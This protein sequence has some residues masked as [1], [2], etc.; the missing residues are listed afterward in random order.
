MAPPT[1]P[2]GPA[3][4][5]RALE[6]GTDGLDTWELQIKIIGWGSGSDNDGIGSVMD[7]VRV[8]GKFDTTT[9]D[10][11]KRFQ[12][13]H[14]L[15]VTGV[16]DGNVFRAI[17]DELQ[18]HPISIS[19][20]QCPCTTGKN[21]GVIPCRCPNHPNAGECK[22]FG[23]GRF[24]GQFLLDGTPLSGEKLAVY[25]MEE[26]AGMDKAV[27]WAVRA[28][29]HRAG[30]TSIKPTAG[31]RCWQDNYFTTDEVRWHHRRSTLHLGHAIELIH[32]KTCI[33]SGKGPCPECE[34]MRQVAL[35][36]CGY[37]L[38]WH[39]LDR[40]TVGE[41]RMDAA[42]PS[43]PFA[44]HIDTV[45]RQTHEKADFVD[46]DAKAAAPLYT[47]K[48]GL[49]LPM[50]LGEGRD[51][52]NAST[53]A[54][55][56]NVEKSQGG[57]YPIGEGRTWHP[58]IHLY[59]RKNKSVY[60]MADGEV[61]ACRAGE[62]EDAKPF[63][64]RNFVIL[65]HTWKSKTLFSLYMHLDDGKASD[66]SKVGWRKQLYFLS[67]DHVEA[68]EANAIYL[69]KGTGAKASLIANPGLGPG[70]RA[71]TDGA[72][73][74][75]QTLD[76][77]APPKSKVVKLKSPKNAYVY[78]NV[79]GKAVA[80][81]NKAE[82]GL[83]DKLTKGDVAGLATPIPVHAGDILGTVGKAAK[84]ASLKPL[85]GFLHLEAFSE[86]SLLTDPGYVAIDASAV[87]KLADRKEITDA[88]VKAKLFTAPADG[89]LL[90]PEIKALATDPNRG[91]FRS[92]V[93]KTENTWAINWKD[94]L[95]AS[96]TLGFMKDAD[97]DAL[98]TA[99][100]DYQWWPAAASGKGMPSGP[101]LYHYHPIV[102]LLQMAYSP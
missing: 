101:V 41:G 26:H 29:M 34:R 53:A 54:V 96:K 21:K 28:L 68:T 84:D 61:V 12:R 64:S 40:V 67:R 76:K 39:E 50:D 102:I 37:Q 81:L 97:R 77:L 86:A 94:A 20:L 92:V 89:V 11:V 87:D 15:T 79:G 2:G 42:Q 48:V 3:Y 19:S 45:M 75:P 10:A 71:E 82:A 51:P 18:A 85:G 55:Y 66:K 33:E 47:G 13:A 23:N 14:G 31:Y 91:R 49:S 95:K 32:P 56:D 1:R 88:L 62:A 17:D 70:E 6:L 100:M 9:R 72:E 5:S 46:T 24:A 65:K 27:L 36:K 98:A 58:G 57:F 43:T 63:G 59:P 69:L 30:V 25:D 22:G 99:F 38:R 80:K 74:D 44:L 4:G 78:T 93:L 7:P 35:A 90:D 16:V 52:K 83:A 60:A 8:H 73:L